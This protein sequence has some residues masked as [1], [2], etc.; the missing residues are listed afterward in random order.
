MIERTRI[1]FP[2]SLVTI[3]RGRVLLIA[4][5]ALFV[6]VLIRPALAQAGAR[7]R[8]DAITI[9]G[10][11][12]DSTGHPIADAFVVLEDERGS[13]RADTKTNTDGS[14]DFSTDQV[15]AYKVRAEKLGVGNAAANLVVLSGVK[16]RH[17]N[18]DIESSTGTDSA[19]SGKVSPSRPSEA[20]IEFQDQPNFTVA[21]VTDWSNVGLHGA[22]TSLRTSE[23]LA[24]ETVALKSGSSPENSPGA[25]DGAAILSDAH[26]SESSLRAALNKAPDSFEANYQLGEYYLAAKTPRDAIPLLET[27]YR[28]DPVNQANAYNLALAYEANGEFTAARDQIRK[29]LANGADGANVHHLLAEAGEQSGDSLL[30]VHEFEIAARLDPS[31]QNYFDW[32]A[33]LLLHRAPV[34]AIEIFTKGSAAYPRSARMLAGLGAAYYASGSYE[35]AALRLCNASDLNPSDPAP[36]IFLGQMEKAT[37]APLPCSAEKLGRF[38]HQQPDNPLPNY[39]YAV[40]LWK[41]ARES[42]N[43]A[44]SR[45]AE[46]LLQRAVKINPH[47]GDAYLQLGVLYSAR[48]DFGRAVPC[49]QKAIEANPRLAEARFRLS[50]AYKQIGEKSKAQQ[51]LQMYK[52]VEKTEAAEI[53]QKRKELQQFLVILGSQPAATA[54]R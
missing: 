9:E 18:L 22:D 23:T 2:C 44:D 41:R 49:Y 31:E 12:R 7:Q 6:S 33:E 32:G 14:F 17:L 43:A 48:N 30:A 21:G 53:E 24:K 13:K 40:V 19:S 50:L 8:R 34:P 46:E 16:I 54:P 51:E 52:Q 10:T 36:Y 45:Q 39:Y 20:T 38:A 27:A 5:V 15:G 35:E 42:D 29:M 37:V 25:P 47:F 4:L 11:V 28:I 3:R 1:V 26:L